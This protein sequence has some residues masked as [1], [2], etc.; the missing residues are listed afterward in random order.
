MAECKALT[1]S[2]VKGLSYQL[3][4]NLLHSPTS[5]KYAFTYVLS[6]LSVTSLLS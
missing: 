2:A 5:T 4:I 3:L 1:G 6:E